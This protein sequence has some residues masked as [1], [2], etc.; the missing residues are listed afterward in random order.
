MALADKDI[1]NWFLENP[2][3]DDATIASTMD[4]FKVAPEDVARATG[5]NLANVQSRYDA[6]APAAVAPPP[7][8]QTPAAPSPIDTLTQQILGQNLSSKWT[9]EGF[10]SAEANAKDMAKILADV[11]VTN[12]K[13]FGKITKTG[14]DTAVQPVYGQGDLVTD[15]EGQTSYSQKII[16]YVDQTGKPVDPSLVKQDTVYS[17][18]DSGNAETVYTAPVGTK[19]VFGNKKT[20]QEVGNTYGERQGNDFFGGT[21]SGKGNTGY[22][23]KFAPDGTPIFYTAGASSNDFAQ[24]MSDLGPVGSIALA[25][26]GGPAA[27]AAMGVLSGKPPGDILKSAALSYLGGQAGNFVSG[28]E[29]I[30]DLLGETGTNLAANAAKQFVGSGGKGVDPVKLLLGSGAMNS[31]LGGSGDGPNSADFEEGYFRPGGEGYMGNDAQDVDSFLKSIGINSVDDL[32]DSGLSN[33]DIQNLIGASNTDAFLQSIGI[34]NVDDLKDSGLS[35]DEIQS[36]INGDLDYLASVDDDFSSTYADEDGTEEDIGEGTDEDT[37]EET[38]TGGSGGAKVAGSGG[39]GGTG[40]TTKIGGTGKTTGTT[41][42]TGTKTTGTKTT[43]VTKTTSGVNSGLANTGATTGLTTNG[44][45]VAGTLAGILTGANTATNPATK[46]NIGTA[47][48]AKNPAVDAVTN[49]AQQQQ[50]RQTNLLNI[51]GGK[52]ELAKIKSYKDLYGEELFGDNYV[53]PSA[54]QSSGEEFSNGGHIDDLSINALLRI[55]RN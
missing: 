17:G 1:V 36:L 2:N 10:G 42:T 9:G 13:D 35:N 19:D 32:A 40:K 43:G 6:V 39:G 34:N 24:L 37:E 3:A 53:P 45:D 26:L 20:G 18:G 28:T 54:A 14:I 7:V 50:D 55:L 15:N 44:A 5:T 30:T 38:T 49:L 21:F 11:G 31:F 16:G 12:I 48:K 33:S 52:D 46:T 27:V 23:V 29:G 25:A 41:K 4:Q 22:G 47:T 51:M 8:V